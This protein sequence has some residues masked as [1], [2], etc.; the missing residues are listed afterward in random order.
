M[1]YTSRCSLPRLRCR[2]CCPARVD[3]CRMP[4][5]CCKQASRCRALV[6]GLLC[7][8]CGAQF[9]RLLAPQHHA[10][11]MSDG[12]VD[13]ITDPLVPEVRDSLHLL[14]SL[15]ANPNVVKVWPL[16][17]TTIPSEHKAAPACGGV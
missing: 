17:P 4:C 9:H 13:Y 6:V 10:L 16:A 8:I 14:R 12:T 15:L 7:R 11:Q 2:I 5:F 3:G 1:G